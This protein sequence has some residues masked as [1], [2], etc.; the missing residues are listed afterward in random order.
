VGDGFSSPTNH[1]LSSCIGK[2]CSFQELQLEESS[3]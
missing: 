2:G 1:F 3:I